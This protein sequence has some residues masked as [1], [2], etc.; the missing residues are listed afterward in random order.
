ME[1]GSLDDYLEAMMEGLAPY[2]ATMHFKG[3]QYVEIEGDRAFVETWVLGHH[4][5]AADRPID[6]LLLV[7]GTGRR[8]A[9]C[10]TQRRIGTG[11]IGSAGVK[12]SSWA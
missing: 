2:A 3:N 7:A 4:F 9:R 10:A 11:V 1:E 6:S 5:E 8:F 12:P